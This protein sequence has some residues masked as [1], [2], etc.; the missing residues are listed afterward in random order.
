MK[1]ATNFAKSTAH[2]VD[3]SSLGMLTQ[4]LCSFPPRSAN[5]KSRISGSPVDRS[6]LEEMEV[7]IVPSKKGLPLTAL[8]L[9]GAEIQQ[10]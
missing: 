1:V 5:V 10:L 6:H 7:A 8:D 4:L 9:G 3:E 2:I